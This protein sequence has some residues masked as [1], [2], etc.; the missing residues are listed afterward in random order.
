MNLALSSMNLK[1]SI[2]RA[3]KTTNGAGDTST[4][5]QV[6]QRNVPCRMN[7]TSGGESVG[8]G[9]EIVRNQT[10][11]EFL[12]T[13]AVNEKDRVVFGTRTFE[14]KS[15]KTIYGPDGKAERLRVL[16]EEVV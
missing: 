9:R 7:D 16:A 6:T 12:T 10:E 8:Y 13:A 5:F 1:V 2:L 3:T 14:V 11:F 15:V 4:V